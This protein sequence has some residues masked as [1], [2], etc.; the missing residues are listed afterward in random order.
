MAATTAAADGL[1]QEIEHPIEELH[2]TIEALTSALI[3]T[4][5]ARGDPTAY[6]LNI[7]VDFERDLLRSV[8]QF[9]PVLQADWTDDL[10]L[11]LERP[12]WLPQHDHADSKKV[13]LDD[14]HALF[15]K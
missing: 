10:D 1:P 15:G 2:S 7:Q 8:P 12:T 9:V 3:E 4:I 14:I 5:T 11:E 6:L 13:F